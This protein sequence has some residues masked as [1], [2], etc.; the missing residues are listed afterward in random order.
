VLTYHATDGVQL[1]WRLSDDPID[2]DT[3]DDHKDPE[4]RQGVKCKIFLGC[5]SNLISSGVRE[6]I[7]FLIEHK[8][9]SIWIIF[10]SADL[11]K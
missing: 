7:R 9:V 1:N 6:T 2:E 5:T 11:C 10:S 4:Y 8:M 3:N